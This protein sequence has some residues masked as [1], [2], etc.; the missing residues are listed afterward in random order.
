[1]IWQR[2]RDQQQSLKSMPAVIEE[3]MQSRKKDKPSIRL[4]LNTCDQEVIH[5]ERSPSPVKSP[6]SGAGSQSP[7]SDPFHWPDVQELR[8]K[9]TETPHSKVTRSC[10]VPNG[11]LEFCTDRSKY[12]SSSDLHKALKDCTRTQPGAVNKEWSPVVEDWPQTRLQPLL[13]RW[14]SLDHM[15]PLHEVQNLQGPTRTCYTTSQVSLITRETDSPL[16]DSDCA[17]KS[18]LTESNLV[19]SL[20]EK[21]QSLSTGS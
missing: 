13:C 19:K 15:I 12:S 14:S 7:Q 18:K 20:R 21:F 11:M 8:T 10:T 5:E 1:M 3:K 17:T 16:Q 9:Y 4:P 6:S 2:S